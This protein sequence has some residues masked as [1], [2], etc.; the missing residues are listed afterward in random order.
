MYQTG[1]IRPGSTADLVLVDRDPLTTD[2]VEDTRVM[3]VWKDG[4]QV[5]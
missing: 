5:V 3:A 4:T 2:Q 1:P